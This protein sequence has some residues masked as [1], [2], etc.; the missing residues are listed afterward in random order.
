MNIEN[1]FN[2]S[3]RDFLMPQSSLSPGE[4]PISSTGAS[5]ADADYSTETESPHSWKRQLESL[6][7]EGV[8]KGET[9]DMVCVSVSLRL[10]F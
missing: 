6:C 5:K 9:L 3:L 4:S 10:S 2:F 7:L 8:I 1:S